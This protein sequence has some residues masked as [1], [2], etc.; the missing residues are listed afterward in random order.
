[1]FFGNRNIK[2][3][4]MFTELER[5]QDNSITRQIKWVGSVAAITPNKKCLR[6]C[7]YARVKKGFG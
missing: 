7:I 1:M 4:K 2:K 6:L 3:R 5:T